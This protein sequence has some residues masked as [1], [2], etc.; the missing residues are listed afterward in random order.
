MRKKY[1]I[2]SLTCWFFFGS[3]LV[4][5]EI[6]VASETFPVFPSIEPNVYFWTEIYTKY[7]TTKGVLHDSVNLD[8]IYDVIELLPPEGYKAR[9]INKARI[10]KAKNKYK[11]ILKNLHRV[12]SVPDPEAARVTALF[13]SNSNPAA[14]RKA[15]YGIRCQI[16][17]KDRFREGLIRSGAYIHKIKQIFSSEGL[18]EDLAYLPLVESSFNPKAYSKFGAAGIWQFTRSTGRRFMNVGYALDE[19]W[20]PIGSSFAA[21]RLLKQNYEKLGEWPMAITA[22]NHGVTGMM[23]AKRARGSYEEIF[24]NYRS[25]IFKFASRNF[26]SEFLAAR[27]VAKA[28]ETYFGSLELD[29]PIECHEVVLNGY[30]SITDLSRNF[31]V[32]IA[33]IRRLNPSLRPPIFREQKYVPKGYA[34]RLPNHAIQ[35][36]P[37]ASAQLPESIYRSHQKPSHFYQVRRGDT[38]DKIAKMHGL[39]ISELILANN[40]DSRATIYVNQNLRLPVPDEKPDPPVTA[41]PSLSFVNRAEPAHVKEIATRD[42]STSDD[43]RVP[44]SELSVEPPFVAGN[45]RIEREVVERG[46]PIG[47]IRV[48]AEET[49]GHYAEWLGI[50]TQKLRHLNDFRYGRVLQLHQEV[51][52]P[53]SE[54]SREQFEEARFEYHQKLQE[55]FLSAYRIDTVQIYRVKKGDSIWTL[56]NEVFKMP[57]WLIKKY[58]PEVDFSDL[59]RS[60]KLMIPVA[61]KWTDQEPDEVA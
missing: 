7:P 38:V 56:C 35:A 11:K 34:L 27:T 1:L 46:E 15:M 32:D 55:D 8:I 10:K 16:G 61:E 6:P 42:M 53:L 43:A 22:Y 4:F 24:K 58:N 59:R 12:P 14:F 47:I 30:V 51:R 9:K 3:T 28:Y 41:S 39:K 44:V 54:V 50:P 31:D 23:R 13:G 2:F 20:D 33:T 52:I 21:A 19:R 60:Q 29:E 40:L 49:L 48:E 45:L 5:A 17:Q 37:D 18:P 36:S 25:R 57:L 26:Y